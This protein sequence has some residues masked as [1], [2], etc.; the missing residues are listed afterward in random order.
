MN[1]GDSENTE[2]IDYYKS[3]EGEGSSQNDTN[4]RMDGCVS[5]VSSHLKVQEAIN[6]CKKP[7]NDN[8]VQAKEF[9]KQQNSNTKNSKALENTQETQKPA[10]NAPRIGGSV[11]NDDSGDAKR[12]T[13]QKNQ[14][15]KKYLIN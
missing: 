11:L 13:S 12:K 1:N 15:P 3:D 8:R 2:I 5:L 9:T 7:V 10:K 14:L 4:I 6:H